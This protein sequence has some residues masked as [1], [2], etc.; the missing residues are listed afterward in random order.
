MLL[1]FLNQLMEPFHNCFNTQYQHSRNTSTVSFSF[2]EVYFGVFWTK[3]LTFQVL[4][5]A[6]CSLLCNIYRTVC[7]NQK[8]INMRKRFD[9]VALVLNF[10]IFLKKLVYIEEI[11]LWMLQQNYG[12][13]QLACPMHFQVFTS[14]FLPFSGL[15]M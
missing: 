12:H 1:C 4:K 8:Y 3:Y 10:S 7:E 2:M 6:K 14:I 15:G 13:P 11:S 9:T 5:D